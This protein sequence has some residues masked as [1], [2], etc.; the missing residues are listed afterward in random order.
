MGVAASCFLF[1]PLPSRVLRSRANRSFKQRNA[2]R[3]HLREQMDQPLKLRGSWLTL[4]DPTSMARIEWL[5][6]LLTQVVLTSLP[7]ERGQG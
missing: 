6:H 1:S 4:A 3:N 5:S 2:V 7:S